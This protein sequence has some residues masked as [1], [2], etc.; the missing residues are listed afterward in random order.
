VAGDREVGGLGLPR[1]A[2]KAMY[3]G[4]ARKL[5]GFGDLEAL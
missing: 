2:L 1:D 5:L 3:Q 4:N